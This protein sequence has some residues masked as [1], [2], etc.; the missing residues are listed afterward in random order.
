MEVVQIQAQVGKLSGHCIYMYLF[1]SATS[2]PH[3][4]HMNCTGGSRGSVTAPVHK[5]IVVIISINN[6]V[7]SVGDHSIT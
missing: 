7:G 2:C 1:R 5:C 4:A 3:E 6:P